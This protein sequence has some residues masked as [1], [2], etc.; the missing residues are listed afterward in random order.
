M[1]HPAPVGKALQAKPQA[2]AVRIYLPAKGAI[3]LMTSPA[4]QPWDSSFVAP[5]TPHYQGFAFRLKF[6]LSQTPS[7]I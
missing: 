7:C 3:P 6:P 2:A 4:F 1:A 5:R